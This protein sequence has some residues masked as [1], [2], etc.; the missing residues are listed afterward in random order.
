MHGLLTTP[1]RLNGWLDHSNPLFPFVTNRGVLFL[2]AW[3]EV[4][5]GLVAWAKRLPLVIRAGALL[6]FACVLIGYQFL[7]VWVRYDGPCGCTFGIN[8]GVPVPPLV[9]QILRDGTP[10]ATVLLTSGL[11]WVHSRKRRRAEGGSPVSATRSST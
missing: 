11:L 2:V 6:C 8:P 3:T 7:L 4:L 1:A 10:P 9:Q 5:V